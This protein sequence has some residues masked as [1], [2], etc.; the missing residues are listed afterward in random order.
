MKLKHWHMYFKLLLA[1]S[2]VDQIIYVQA[3][4]QQIKTRFQ[5]IMFCYT[6]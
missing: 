2:S 1:Y 6:E 5:S 3:S 4:K